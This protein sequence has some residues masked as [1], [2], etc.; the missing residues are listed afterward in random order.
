[1]RLLL[2]FVLLYLTATPLSA[3]NFAFIDQGKNISAQ[4]ETE[5]KSKLETLYD[6]GAGYKIVMVNLKTPMTIALINQKI[7]TYKNQYDMVLVLGMQKGTNHFAVAGEINSAKQNSTILKAGALA[8]NNLFNQACNQCTEYE[9]A[10]RVLLFKQTA[11]AM[12]TLNAAADQA[13][14]AGTINARWQVRPYL[15]LTTALERKIDALANSLRGRVSDW[16]AARVIHVEGKA[17]DLT[18]AQ[19]VSKVKRFGNKVKADIASFYTDVQSGS[20]TGMYL[21]G[22]DNRTANHPVHFNAVGRLTGNPIYYEAAIDKLRHSAKSGKLMA[23]LE[24]YAAFENRYAWHNLYDLYRWLGKEVWLDFD[25]GAGATTGDS[26]RSRRD[27]HMYKFNTLKDVTVP[28]IGANVGFASLGVDDKFETFLVTYKH[29]YKPWTYK[30]YIGCASVNTTA[31]L[32]WSV[33]G[34]DYINLIAYDGSP[35]P[36]GDNINNAA[37]NHPFHFSPAFWRSDV[38]YDYTGAATGSS[39]SSGTRTTVLAGEMTFKGSDRQI[40]VDAAGEN[41]QVNAVNTA[42]ATILE[43][44]I[45]TGFCKGYGVHLMTGISNTLSQPASV[46][47]HKGKK[48]VL[49]RLLLSFPTG[50][51]T[52]T[53]Q[54]KNHLNEVVQ[55]VVMVDGL[56]GRKSEIVVHGVAGGL[57]SGNTVPYQLDDKTG[58]TGSDLASYDSYQ[59][60]KGLVTPV[61]DYIKGELRTK[62]VGKNDYSIDGERRFFIPN[63]FN[64]YVTETMGADYDLHLK[65]AGWRLI[66]VTVA[67]RQ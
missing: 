49:K 29:R 41:Y 63:S 34:T 2:I 33:P 50:A 8:F 56:Y 27:V 65:P 6:G 28:G 40:K 52:L 64:T 48:V 67:A 36:Q 43:S 20:Y 45:G 17:G 4:S 35:L 46:A 26:R 37:R 23:A 21:D 22:T 58:L 57:W 13:N 39:G 42:G 3:Q 32:G 5:I 10:Q 47:P 51:T 9:P 61:A 16:E 60:V 11:D 24:E 7:E 59:T 44:G 31:S 55:D 54:Q 14:A 15:P 38:K 19:Y 53:Q 12:L 66:L 62:G 30:M 18:H 1:M 25:Q